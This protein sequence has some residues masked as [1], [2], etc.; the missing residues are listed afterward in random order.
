[1]NRIRIPAGLNDEDVFLSWGPIKLSMRQLVTATG[2]GF[3]WF[4]SA[5]YFVMPI[6]G[7]TLFPAMLMTVWVMVMFLIL[8]FIKVNK[9]PI[10]VWIGEKISFVFSPRTYILRD[11]ANG[12]TQVDSD[13]YSDDDLDSMMTHVDRSR[14]Y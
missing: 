9:R 7:L 4:G 10:D 11:N 1:M 13:M 8:A 2:G 14:A 6:I 5:K 3:L 12:N